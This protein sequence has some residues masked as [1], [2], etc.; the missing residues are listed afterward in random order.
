LKNVEAWK[1]K[2]IN[3]MKLEKLE[4]PDVKLITPRRFTDSRGWFSETFNN[5]ALQEAGIDLEFVQDNHSYSAQAGTVRGLHYQSPP[6]AQVKLVR[7]IKG[8]VLDIVVDARIGS[9]SE[10]QWVSAELSAQNGAQLL[11]PAGFLHGFITL[12]PDTEIV[13][14]VTDYYS[15]S[16]DGAV[17]WNDS[18]LGLDWGSLAG[19]AILSEKDEA[20]PRW[21][22]FQSPFLY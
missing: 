20:A 14:K 10:G 1:E 6:H 9:P 2:R 19:D 21:V 18:D 13:Y 4:I 15:G 3:K 8:S 22:E 11:V 16:C 7:A 5:K 17:L 12:E